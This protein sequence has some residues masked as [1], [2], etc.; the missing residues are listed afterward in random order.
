MRNES[1][2]RNLDTSEIETLLKNEHYRYELAIKDGAVSSILN[3]VIKRIND[4]Q[5]ELQERS[6]RQLDD[7]YSK[8]L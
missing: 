2:V 3:D 8:R 7:A 4:L 5:H 1:S 6:N